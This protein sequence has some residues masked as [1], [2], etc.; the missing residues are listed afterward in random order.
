MNIRLLQKKDRKSFLKLVNTFRPINMEM[1]I[2]DFVNLYD[3]VFSTSKIFV[4]VIDKTIQG[5]ITLISEQKFIHNGSIYLHIEDLIVA[6]KYQGKGIGSELLDF[7]ISYGRN[8][9][10]RKIILNCS[11]ELKNF[12]QKHNFIEDKIQMSNQLTQSD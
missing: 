10:V 4:Y 3:N 2:E 1:D 5:C 7:A 12:Y 11:I 9:K 6:P 8:L